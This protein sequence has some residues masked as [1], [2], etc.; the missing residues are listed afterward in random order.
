MG[1]GPAAKVIENGHY[2]S[3]YFIEKLTSISFKPVPPR[4]HW[5]AG[6][7][8]SQLGACSGQDFGTANHI[9]AQIVHL[10]LCP[11]AC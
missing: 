7:Q 3:F 9:P 11:G 1:Q 4:S 10:L 8:Q 5:P 6:G 2:H